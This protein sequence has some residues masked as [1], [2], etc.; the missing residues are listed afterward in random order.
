MYYE[1]KADRFR[2]ELDRLRPDFEDKD[3]LALLAFARY[4]YQNRLSKKRVGDRF[5][6]IFG[7]KKRTSVA[8]LCK[9]VLALD[10]TLVH[11]RYLIG[12]AY[13]PYHIFKAKYLA[14]LAH[15][16]HCTDSHQSWA[17]HQ[18]TWI[19]KCYKNFY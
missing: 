1:R 12:M 19:D 6:D 16:Q 5:S 14:C 3:P 10:P 4:C 15:F 17:I 8:E 18:R 13:S 7:A 11:A 2:E 9:K